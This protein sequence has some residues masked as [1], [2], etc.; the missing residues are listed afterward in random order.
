MECEYVKEGGERCQAMAV[1]GDTCCF[2]HSAL[3]DIVEKRI[4]AR[5]EGGR[6]GR[7]MM[8]EPAEV[9]VAIKSVMDV[10]TLLEQTVNDVR[11]NR[12][13]TNQANCIGFLCGIAMKAMEKLPPADDENRVTIEDIIKRMRVPGEETNQI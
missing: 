2:A 6:N 5:A 13:T 12:V 8:L 10:V 9:S 4:M 11:Q 7:K 3:P 1:N